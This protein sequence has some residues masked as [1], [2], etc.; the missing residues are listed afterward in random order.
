MRRA[1]LTGVYVVDAKGVPQ[2]RQVRLGR[3]LGDGV[4]VL[5]GVAAGERVATDPQAAARVR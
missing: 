5:A 3:A 4:E 2:L 1:E